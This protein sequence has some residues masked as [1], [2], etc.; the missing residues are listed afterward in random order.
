MGNNVVVKCNMDGVAEYVPGNVENNNWINMTR[1]SEGLD[2][3]SL[4]W[5]ETGGASDST[6]NAA[7]SNYD[8]GISAD[9]IFRDK[10]FQYIF[11]LLLDNPCGILNAVEVRIEDLLCG[12][13]Y[14]VFEIKADNLSYKPFDEPCELSV[15]IR[16][17]DLVW[18]CVH[19]TMIWD[20]WQHW[21]EDNSS[22]EHPCFLTGIE[23]RPRLLNSVRMGLLLFGISFPVVPSFVLGSTDDD[24]RRI[25]QI[26]NFIPA[27]LVR[28]YIKN[29]CDKCGIAMDTIFDDDPGNDYRNL[30]VY[31]PIAGDKY[32]HKDDGDG[33]A[34]GALWF[35]FENRWN[36][37]L[38]DF[39]DDLKKV[40]KAEWYVTPNSTLVFKNKG[41]FKSLAAIYDFSLP[42]NME[43]YELEYTF[44]GNKK[45]AY[46]N[47]KYEVDGVDLAAQEISPLYNDVVDYDGLANNPM[48]EGSV[49]T[50]L[51]FSPTG[52]IRDGRCDDYIRTL[53]NDG[54]TIGYVLV[55]L[56]TLVTLALLPGIFT[57]AS[58][59]ILG[60]SV[61][62][63]T[64]NIASH[65]N[66]W[67]DKFGGWNNE[68]TGAV[69]MTSEQVTMPRL[70]MWDGE[71]KNRAKVVRQGVPVPNPVYNPLNKTYDS[72]NS[73]NNEKVIFNYPMYFDSW[74]KDNLYDRFHEKE[75]N[76][77][78][79]L[80][81]FQSF[82]F[83]IDLCCEANDIFGL[84]EGQFARIGYVIKIEQRAKYSVY[85]KI[86][87]IEVDYDNE[88]IVLRGQVMK[89]LN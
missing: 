76:P 35:F 56:L 36:E 74:Y 67:R 62:L 61:L 1:Y 77:L 63:F 14:R 8:K 6:T 54:E 5:S 64:I 4:D 40:F 11:N 88:E 10:A 24:A 50:S 39:L 55:G 37:A 83:K 70:L 38:S 23:P 32:W 58:G 71:S 25:L 15:K 3:L 51:D 57:T 43:I 7:G 22:K 9:V 47:Y 65:A 16:E 59:I 69:R 30:C 85:G 2:K 13:A 73:I 29:V 81:T 31:Y 89:R 78:Q 42:G 12:K 19:K 41:Y 82:K 52:F 80:E 33:V 21:F 46:G 79:S 28:D 53:I 60:A 72:R 45:A 75:D 18:H 17:Q 44:D 34:T 84:W 20:N 27:P 86:K 66:K 48:L 68:Y 49:I 26:N 87:K